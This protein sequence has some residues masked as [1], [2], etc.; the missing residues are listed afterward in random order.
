MSEVHPNTVR[1]TSTPEH[2]ARGAKPG[3]ARG[4]SRAGVA[5]SQ[6]AGKGHDEQSAILR[7]SAGPGWPSPGTAAIQLEESQPSGRSMPEPDPRVADALGR[8]MAALDRTTPAVLGYATAVA[9]RQSEAWQAFLEKTGGNGLL[10]L[11]S[12]D[13]RRFAIG[14]IE[15]PTHLAA[16]PASMG[17]LADAGGN[18]GMA[19]AIEATGADMARSASR[20]ATSKAGG[21]MVG[22]AVAAFAGAGIPGFV[23]DILVNLLWSA[24]AGGDDGKTAYDAAKQATGQ[25]F[26]VAG[27]IRAGAS[28]AL[29]KWLTK[30]SELKAALSADAM[31]I[32][33]VESLVDWLES[34]LDSLSAPP[35]LDPMA[36]ADDLRNEWLLQHAGDEED[37]NAETSEYAYAK[38]RT[39]AK[40]ADEIQGN[41]KLFVHQCKYAWGRLGVDLDEPVAQLTKAVGAVESLEAAAVAGA[42]TGLR[43]PLRGVAHPAVFAQNLPAPGGMP[44]RE[45]VTEDLEAAAVAK[46]FDLHCTLDLTDED[47]TVFINRFDYELVPNAGFDANAAARRRDVPQSGHII[48]RTWSAS[49]D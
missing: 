12:A 31:G 5:R 15:P 29:R 2:G 32:G 49:P 25:S 26:A 24:V 27:A 47:G 43:V 34:N 41:K 7:P 39:A 33:D 44:L 42:L 35:Q 10:G 11:T 18:A 40:K 3:D 38:T 6:L 1:E 36:L 16:A 17:A 30:Q 23:L 45:Q 8:A 28:E 46:T 20:V 48:P 37:A 21:A 4:S 22:A 13:R 19:K 9:D 14:P